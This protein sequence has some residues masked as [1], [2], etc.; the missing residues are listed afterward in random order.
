[1]YG[2]NKTNGELTME[3]LR[4]KASNITKLLLFTA[5]QDL[6]R[7]VSRDRQDVVISASNSFHDSVTNSDRSN[8]ALV[9]GDMDKY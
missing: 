4:A 1:M 9:S 3:I 6:Y 7:Q 2:E 5:A 8:S